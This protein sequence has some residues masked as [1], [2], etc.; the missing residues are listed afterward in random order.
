GALSLERIYRRM[1]APEQEPFFGVGLETAIRRMS[2]EAYFVNGSLSLRQ[3]AKHLGVAV[4]DESV[5]TVAG[6][7]QRNNQRL[8]RLGDTAE[9]ERFTL[10]VVE[11][12]DDDLEIEVTLRTDPDSE[13]S[14]E[15]GQSW[16]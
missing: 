4:P 14:D 8:P 9:L 16:R 6:F 2:D 7:I 11:E 13:G 5:A 1:L 3:L 12:L 15:G 10:S